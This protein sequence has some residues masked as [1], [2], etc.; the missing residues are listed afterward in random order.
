MAHLYE[1][2]IPPYPGDVDPRAVDRY[3][4]L[5][6]SANTIIPARFRTARSAGEDETPRQ[7]NARLA[8]ERERVERESR[9]LWLRMR[10]EAARE[11]RERGYEAE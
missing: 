6:G 5:G 11:L 8:A 1:R 10:R 9:K 3:F 2:N 4:E 7:Q